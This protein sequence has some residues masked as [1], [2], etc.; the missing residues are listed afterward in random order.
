MKK[1]L[2]IT[3]GG[4]L[5][6]FEV[7][8]AAA[9]S[10]CPWLISG[11]SI[12]PDAS[13]GCPNIYKEATSEMHWYEPWMEGRTNGRGQCYGALEC[14]PTFFT[15]YVVAAGSD[16]NWVYSYYVHKI[17][18]KTVSFPEYL[19]TTLN[20]KAA[21]LLCSDTQHTIP[22]KFAEAYAVSPKP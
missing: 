6:F 2:I 7:G 19:I 9:F 15:P 13:T 18:E 5:F 10:S 4:L 1:A 16:T 17:Q 22:G 14:W 12:D 21:V 20:H 3:L 8:S 11:P